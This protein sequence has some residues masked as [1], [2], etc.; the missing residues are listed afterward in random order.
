[1][2]KII[3]FFTILVSHFSF[4]QVTIYEWLNTG[5]ENA[6]RFSTDYFKNA[7]EG[8]VNSSSNG[9]Y[10]SAKAKE[11]LDFEVGMVGN[12]SFVRDEKRSF[13][14]NQ[15]D[16]QN[17]TF[18]NGAATQQVDNV[19]GTNE[20][21]VVI[22]SS[23]GGIPISITLPDG[24]GESGVNMIPGAYLQGSIGLIKGTEIKARFLPPVTIRDTKMMA[25]GLGVQNELTKWISGWE[26]FPVHISGIIGYTFF[27]ASYDLGEN[28]NIPGANQEIQ[29]KSNSLLIST[30]VS[31]K[32]PKYNVYGGVGFYTGK[33]T[34]TLAGTY[35]IAT[36]PLAN[37]TLV[38]P[39][40]ATTKTNGPKATLGMSAKFGIFNVNIDY[41]LQN[42]QNISIGGS[43]GW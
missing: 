36:G 37:Q 42:Y 5:I 1:M 28:S 34:S 27:K 8:V 39:I 25:Y 12:I 13:I 41:T 35:T 9:W 23:N 43:F 40:Q 4:S 30:I 2:Q 10:T 17:I 32:F 31:T 21:E 15:D 18:Q 3:L 26:R 29:F 20:R 22:I 11:W 6:Q 16:Y 7:A 24:I 19:F 38:D 14:M 33:S